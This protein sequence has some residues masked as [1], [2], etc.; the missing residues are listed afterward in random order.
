[1]KRS[2]F[3]FL[4]ILCV[5]SL[6]GCGKTPA[7]N[8]DI[9]AEADVS[10]QSG[11]CRLSV[12]NP[13]DSIVITMLSP[14]NIEGII[15]RF[16]GDTL[17]LEYKG[18]KCAAN[19]GYLPESS[20]QTTLYNAIGAIPGAQYIHTE[21]GKDFFSTYND[22]FVIQAKEGTITEIQDTKYGYCFTFQE[23]RE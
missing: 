10:T 11:D 18:L 4:I 17:T 19:S 9:A 21:E 22:R 14:D 20:I 6:C 13:D 3:T 23:S 15:Y 12:E 1:M 8:T 5:I 7:L 2:V 16:E